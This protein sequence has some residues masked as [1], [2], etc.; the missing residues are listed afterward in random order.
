M[1]NR[2]MIRSCQLYWLLLPYLLVFVAACNSVPTYPGASESPNTQP[3]RSDI[4]TATQAAATASP[5]LN[6]SKTPPGSSFPTQISTV[7]FPAT[8]TPFFPDFSGTII[9]KPVLFPTFDATTAL[10]LTPASPETCPPANPDLVPDLDAWE[11]DCQPLESCPQIAPRILEYLNSGG[12]LSSVVDSVRQHSSGELGVS[13]LTGDGVP[14]LFFVFGDLLIIGCDDGGY[15]PYL[16]IPR[17]TGS[18]YRILSVGDMNLDGLPELIFGL[19]EFSGSFTRTPYRIIGWNGQQFDNLITEPTFQSRYGSGGAGNH[20]VWMDNAG[21][22]SSWWVEDIDS[23]GT[24]EFVVSGGL[25]ATR[26]SIAEGPFRAETHTY[27][28]DGSGFRL[29]RTEIEP[30]DY[31]FQAVQDADYAVL[32]GDYNRALELYQAVIISDELEWW[33]EQRGWNELSRYDAQF[34]SDGATPTL[35]APDLNEYYYLAGYAH[36]RI[37]VLNVFLD[38][39]PEAQAVY[40][41]LVENFPAG[42]PGSDYAYMATLFWNE[43]QSS[44][45]IGSACNMAVAYAR[46]HPQTLTYLGS[47]NHGLQSNQYTPEELCPFGY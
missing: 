43:Y 28:W 10:T 13:D 12:T 9:G 26:L 2:S 5:D 3:T 21:R 24:L 44:Q 47:P 19:Y 7:T 6:L 11:N 45:N 39:F 27:M 14:E 35:I 17:Y 22:F 38:L 31:R 8:Q 16:Q 46:T 29:Y 15:R 40:K 30:P 37:M 20:W 25:P 18:F 23:N 4:N 34:S 36:F 42:Q 41:A 33:S 1:T 32:D